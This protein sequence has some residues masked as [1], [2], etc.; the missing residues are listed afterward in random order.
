MKNAPGGSPGRVRVSPPSVL[1]V[2]P[3]ADM[4]GLDKH[5]QTSLWGIADSADYGSECH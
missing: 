4:V 3:V 2:A 1:S 5:R